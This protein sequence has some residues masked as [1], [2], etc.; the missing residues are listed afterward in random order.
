MP[1]GSAT[2]SEYHDKEAGEREE[3]LQKQLAQLQKAR[4]DAQGAVQDAEG[5]LAQAQAD[6]AAGT[7]FTCFNSTVRKYKY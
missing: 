2:A 1:A 7:H 6:M 5:R 3:A 4:S